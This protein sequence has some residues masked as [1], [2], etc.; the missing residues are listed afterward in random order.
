MVISS[1]NIRIKVMKVRFYTHI[2]AAIIF[3][4]ITF[5]F[6]GLQEKVRTD[7]KKN[8]KKR[9]TSLCF[10]F[11][12]ACLYTYKNHHSLNRVESSFFLSSSRL[13]ITFSTF[14]TTLSKASF[15]APSLDVING[16][17]ESLASAIA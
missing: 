17:P 16:S 3:Y 2:A 15:V 8:K 11:I 6:L 5:R 1:N 7:R 12:P 13:P 4:V 10:P 14:S 9:G